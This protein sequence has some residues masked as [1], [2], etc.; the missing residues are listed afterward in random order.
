MDQQGTVT[1]STQQAAEMLHEILSLVGLQVERVYNLDGVL[2]KLHREHVLQSLPY[3]PLVHLRL[4]PVSRTQG[5]RVHTIEPPRSFSSAH[6]ALAALL[7]GAK[8]LVGTRPLPFVEL[9]CVAVASKL[10]SMPPVNLVYYVL[11]D[12]KAKDTIWNYHRADGS[13]GLISMEHL[14]LLHRQLEDGVEA[15]RGESPPVPDDGPNVH[16]ITWPHHP[17]RII[18]TWD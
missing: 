8:L 9:H 1:P 12:G 2:R 17:G 13:I 5:V 10:P 18:H 4:P 7:L 11:P 15:H 16:G 14:K 3:Y 6:A